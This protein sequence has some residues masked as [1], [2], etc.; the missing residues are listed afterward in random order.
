ML[1]YNVYRR[2]HNVEDGITKINSTPMERAKAEE[3]KQYLQT[4]DQN[5]VYFIRE[6]RLS[7]GHEVHSMRVY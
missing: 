2:T 7:R 3:W 1:K 6:N 5:R 4:K